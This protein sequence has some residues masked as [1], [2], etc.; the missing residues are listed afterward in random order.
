M[1]EQDELAPAIEQQ[2]QMVMNA[3]A[4]ML[5]MRFMYGGARARLRAQGLQ[6]DAADT[7]ALA[8]ALENA[9]DAADVARD[10]L[11]N[12]VA[13]AADQNMTT[14]QQVAAID[15]YQEGSPEAVAIYDK[16]NQLVAD[17]G[18]TG[19]DQDALV[20]ALKRNAVANG[21]Q[22][23]AAGMQDGTMMTILDAV[24]ARVM[25]DNAALCAQAAGG[26]SASRPATAQQAAPVVPVLATQRAQESSI[27]M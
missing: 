7:D 16:I 18:A 21:A 15:A 9:Q 24:D 6:A 2:A 25:A 17:Y 14:R 1:A 4:Q 3:V 22:S 20:A 8:G 13:D 5:Q 27:G 12:L 26:L 10:D 11:A 19:G 23:E